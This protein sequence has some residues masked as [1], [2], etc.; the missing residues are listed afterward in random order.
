MPAAT[1][2]DIFANAV[3]RL[4]SPSTRQEIPFNALYHLGAQGPD[5]L[6]FS[7]FPPVIPAWQPLASPPPQFEN[8]QLKYHYGSP[9][10]CYKWQE[11]IP[12]RG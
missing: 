7:I 8:H 4:Y 6:F 10:P 2:H 11:H 9:E 5:F 1:T 12:D 3:Y